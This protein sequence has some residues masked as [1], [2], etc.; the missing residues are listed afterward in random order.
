[1]PTAARWLALPFLLCAAT[2]A[3]AASPDALWH[4]VHDKCAPDAAASGNPAPCEVV[5][6]PQ[7]AASGYVVMKDIR[8]ATQFLTIPAA[9]I[10][11]I[12]D[13]AILAPDATN[14]FAAAWRARSFMLARLGHDL[15][16]DAI[17]LAINSPYGRSQNQ[18][19]I[20]ID[21]L[22][23]DVRDALR[24]AA[25]TIGPSFAPLPAPLLGHRYR[26]RT[27]ATPDL[28]GVNPFDVLADDP[29]VGHA[30]VKT[31]TL[32]AVG[33]QVGGRDG[34]VLLDDQLDAAAGDGASG[35]ELQ[36]H[37]CAVGR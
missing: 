25:A 1:M 11:G 36:D 27:L 35:E 12:E 23:A 34:F 31:H 26:A 13:P 37:D 5:A 7:G 30:G 22:R 15:P 8:G 4:I 24:A 17:S 3:H 16:R 14:Y 6:Y 28:D 18:L 9:K 10:T 32:V 2:A 33:A 29:A 20:H 19:H 21:C